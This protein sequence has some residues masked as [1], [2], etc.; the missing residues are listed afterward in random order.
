MEQTGSRSLGI[1][2]FV[3]PEDIEE[4]LQYTKDNIGWKQE[5]LDYHG[6]NATG[7]PLVPFIW[8]DFRNFGPVDGP[9]EEFGF[10][11][12]LWEGAPV[13]ENDRIQNFDAFR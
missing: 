3:Q 7:T 8:G 1:A 11:A 2:H 10:Y 9:V 4:W 6:S 12:P 5:S 13:T